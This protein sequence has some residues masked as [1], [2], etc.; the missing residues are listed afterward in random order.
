MSSQTTLDQFS[1]DELLAEIFARHARSRSVA[2]GSKSLG[3][4]HTSV[5]ADYP[6]PDLIATL[7]AKQKSIY[8]VDDRRDL[9]E[10]NMPAVL[11]DADSVVSLFKDRDVVDNGDGTSTLTTRRFGTEY[12]LCPREAFSNQPIGAFCSGFLVASTVIAT[13]GH[14]VTTDAAAARTRFVF[15]YRMVDAT[16]PTLI[17]KNSDIYR[18]VALLGR[19]Q[20]DAGPDW[21]LV[22]LDRPVVGHHVAPINRTGKVPGNQAVHVIGHPV[23]LP[24]KYADGARVNDNSPEAYFTANL[25]TFGG[26]SGSPVFNSVTH[27][28]EGVLVRGATDF[29]AKGDCFVAAKYPN[30]GSRGEDC[31]RTTEFAALVPE[32]FEP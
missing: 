27:V 1:P 10:V 4:P 30:T 11:R 24:L 2:V 31:T 25:D 22:Q 19:K 21:A 32:E 14:C 6:T 28:V 12:N 15:G 7:L 29:I 17:V 18:G 9:Y 8:G 20:I 26:N 5:L 16:T 13:A 23:G 3:T